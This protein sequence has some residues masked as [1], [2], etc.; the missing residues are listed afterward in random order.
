MVALLTWPTDDDLFAASHLAFQE[1]EQL[2]STVGIDA[3]AVLARYQHPLPPKTH[4]LPTMEPQC[5][6]MLHDLLQY[7]VTLTP[8]KPTIEDE[9]ELCEMVLISLD[10]DKTL[11]MYDPDS[12]QSQISY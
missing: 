8:L 9:V 7:Y 6:Q 10:V 2:L 4:D 11:F 1:V 3:Q 5:P 12:I